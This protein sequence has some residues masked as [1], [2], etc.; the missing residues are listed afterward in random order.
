VTTE[1]FLAESRASSLS[2]PAYLARYGGIV[3]LGVGDA[4]ASVAGIQYGK[5]KWRATS[6]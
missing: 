4:V 3:T 6:K 2:D 5:T 1:V